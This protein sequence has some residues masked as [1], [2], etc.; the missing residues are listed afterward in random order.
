MTG[1]QGKFWPKTSGRNYSERKQKTQFAFLC[2]GLP[3][4][5]SFKQ[6]GVSHAYQF[7][8]Y[9][10]FKAAQCYFCFEPFTKYV[11]DMITAIK[12]FK[13][14]IS[15]YTFNGSIDRAQCL[16]SKVMRSFLASRLVPV[17]W[18]LWMSLLV[19]IHSREL[20]DGHESEMERR[21][22]IRGLRGHPSC[23]R[24]ERDKAKQPKAWG[25]PRVSSAPR[26]RQN[27]EGRSFREIQPSRFTVIFDHILNMIP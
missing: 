9:D 10:P 22:A 12:N 7:S 1:Y 6:A 11:H 5:S 3:T 14:L 27:N 23:P 25:L 4:F 21:E 2:I 19:Q 24:R 16:A 8:I 20:M 26:L 18:V 17:E 15:I 13:L